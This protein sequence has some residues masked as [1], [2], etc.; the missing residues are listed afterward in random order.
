VQL[1][2]RKGLKPELRELMSKNYFFSSAPAPQAVCLFHLP[3]LRMSVAASLSARR[4]GSL[5][6][7]IGTA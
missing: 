4:I 6:N 1:L 7:G 2:V 5:V 3:W